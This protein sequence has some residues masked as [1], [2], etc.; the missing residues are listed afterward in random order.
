MCEDN[1][2]DEKKKKKKKPSPDPKPIRATLTLTRSQSDQISNS[3]PRFYEHVLIFVGCGIPLPVVL[4]EIGSDI[5]P[6]GVGGG[7]GGGEL[8]TTIT[9]KLVHAC[10]RHQIFETDRS[11]T[12][13]YCNLTDAPCTTVLLL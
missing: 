12:F 6:I 7:G 3:S 5:R 9:T 10:T 13:T 4:E 8:Y 11:V 2:W 1:E